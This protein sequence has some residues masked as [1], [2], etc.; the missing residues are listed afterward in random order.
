[1]ISYTL[2]IIQYITLVALSIGTGYVLNDIVK[3]IKK[4][5]FFDWEQK[6]KLGKKYLTY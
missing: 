2:N 1:M 6:K 3:A 5:D 4:G